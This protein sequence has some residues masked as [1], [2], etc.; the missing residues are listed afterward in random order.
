MS[1]LFKVLLTGASGFLG[2]GI[3]SFN[4]N[5]EIQITPVLRSGHSNTNN[6]AFYISDIVSANWDSILPGHDIIIHTAAIAHD[7]KGKP[8]LN[9]ATYRKI[10]V[11]A[12]KSLAEAAIR[13]GI[14]R[15]IFIS[16][17]KVNGESTKAGNFSE[18][19]S[20]QPLDPYGISKM[21]AESILLE[22]SQNS[23]LE[24]VI[25]R[26]PLIYGPGV[27]A[28]F[29]SS[30]RL[31]DTILPLPF[32]SIHSLRSMVYLGNL[33]DFI[34]RCLD[35]P[36]AKNQIFLISDQNDLTIGELFKQLRKALNRSEFIFPFPLFI[37][38]FAGWIF[39]RQHLI[40][41]LTTPLQ[42]D[43]QKATKQL[44]WTP[45]FSVSRGIQIT[46]NEFTQDKK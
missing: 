12:T 44:K 8:E 19:D 39:R 10:N 31:A 16:T 26:P 7:T 20:P 11:D 45:P 41:R 2:Q 28:N 1:K 13:C 21:E 9:L 22:F 37:L 34:F 42:I 15:F 38:K 23:N 27:K 46:V 40:N 32:G 3:I 36:K 30:I 4:S 24:V 17:I 43:S 18:S 6:N 33:V 14:K 29:L 25:I 5:P 35:H